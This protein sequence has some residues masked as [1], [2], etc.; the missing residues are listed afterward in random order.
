M[1]AQQRVQYG[2]ANLAQ[3]GLGTAQGVLGTPFSYNGPGLQTSIGQGGA[4][5]Y[6]PS[7]GSYQAQGS[8]Q[9]RGISA[10]PSAQNA[11]DLS[12][13]AKQDVNAGMTG[14]N[15][16]LSR[17][18]PQIQQ[19]NAAEAQQLANQGITP[20]S[21]AYNNAMR[22]QGQQNNDLYTQ[23][24]LQGIGIDQSANAQG[25][26][27]A[28]QSAGLYNSALGQNFSQA[29]GA[30]GQQN[31][32]IA[33]NLQANNAAM[34]QNYGQAATSAGLYNQA[35]N[36][37]YNQELQNAQFGNQAS[38]QNYQQQLAQYNQPLNQITALMSGS[39][40]QNPQ[41]QQYTG[42]NIQ[43]API[44]NATTQAGQY[45]Q[46]LYGQQVAA[47]NA[48]NQA[49]GSAIG[50]I[51][52]MFAG[53]NFSDIRLKSNIARIG[54]HPL[55]IGIYEYDIFGH[56]KIGVMAHEVE[57]VMPEAVLIHSSGYK[58]VN[59]GALNG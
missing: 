17:L 12:G 15:A 24:A 44:A 52:G 26:N 22:T 2:E 28:L 53:T 18:N 42:Q 1:D 3:Q 23:A 13:I 8:D 4:L 14:Q 19:N 47:V 36:Q 33:Q 25:Y 34:A 59:Y 57:A 27:Q 49:I 32:A 46:N 31:A 43:A 40:I 21:E 50:S 35:Q 41:F 56:R 5:N 6:G 11:L 16:I 55:G 48:Q 39:Q 38:L 7:A 45:A 9:A 58:M 37:Q 20:G 51:P 54:T 10:G 30:Q 29:Y